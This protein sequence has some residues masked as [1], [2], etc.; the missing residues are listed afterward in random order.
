MQTI[1]GTKDIL[2]SEIHKWQNLYNKAL[3]L[4]TLNNYLEIRTPVIEYKEIFTKGIGNET[5]ITNKEI[6]SFLDQGNRNI[7]LRPE[8]TASVA[9]AIINHRLYQN[10][11]IQKLWY[12]G[13]MFRYERP[14]SGRQRQFHQLG[15]EYIG[16]HNP[17][18]D[19]EIINLTQN[20][21]VEF[22]CPTYTIEINS[23]GTQEERI[24]YIAALL[25]YI[26]KF[27]HELDI[28]SQKR[29]LTNPLRIL[30]SKNTKTQEIIKDSPCISKYLTKDS[31]KHFET[32]CEHLNT[33]NI[34]YTINRKL[35]RGLDYYTHTAFE[36]T[37]NTLGSKNT[38]CG[39]GRY[40]HLIQ[41]LGGPDIP[42]VGCAIG[43]ERLLMLD[44]TDKTKNNNRFHIIT[45]SNEAQKKAW[46]LIQI[47]QQQKI[48][49][50][51][52]FE[53]N[54]LQKQIKKAIKN[55]AFA[56]LNL[57]PDEII[58]QTITVKCIKQQ[59]QETIN[60]DHIIDYIIKNYY[61]Q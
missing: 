7:A 19:V 21:L 13:P 48:N 12:I 49:F 52:E 47:L 35:V 54:S 33:L 14:Q 6:Y 32:V 43:I 22:N 46:H 60:Y 23:I 61:K 2:P 1:R 17:L 16:S 53:N 42:G 11:T 3:N 39:G 38:I 40:S 37:N 4:L 27:K 59:I 51:I 26:E 50:H 30:D 15:I 57:G 5:D 31:I 29:L 45:Q 55:N 34:N 56:C 20:L 24:N 28:D 58:N 44:N 36:I 25:N 9:R 8:G 41:S 10:N 18:S